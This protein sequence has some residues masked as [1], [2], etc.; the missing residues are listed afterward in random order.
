MQIERDGLYSVKDL[1]RY[2]QV[3]TGTI[4]QSHEGACKHRPSKLGRRLPKPISLGGSL[5][6]T[7]GQV[8]DFVAAGLPGQPQPVPEPA[9]IADRR[10]GRGRPRK[11]SRDQNKIQAI[12]RGGVA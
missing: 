10:R 5:R 8:L 11:Q 12:G 6:W 4:Y 3:S 2:F 1:A 7:G 9:Q